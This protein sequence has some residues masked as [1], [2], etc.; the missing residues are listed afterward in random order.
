MLYESY[1][2][3]RKTRVLITVVMG[4]RALLLSQYSLDQLGVVSL[5]GGAFQGETFSV[6]R[7]RRK[8]RFVVF[9]FPQEVGSTL[10]FSLYTPHTGPKPR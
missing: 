5:S 4:V 1:V 6:S 2:N 10:P 7:E 9:P 3:G 8:G